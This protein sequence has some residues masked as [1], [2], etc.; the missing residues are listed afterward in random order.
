MPC[1][2]FIYSHVAWIDSDGASHGAPLLARLYVP[3][4][5]AEGRLPDRCNEYK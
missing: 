4:R 2:C 3:I 1:T 5:P